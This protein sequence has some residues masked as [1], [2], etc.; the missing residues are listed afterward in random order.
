FKVSSVFYSKATNLRI[1]IV[2]YKI[3]F[4]KLIVLQ[5]KEPIDINLGKLLLTSDVIK[6]KEIVVKKRKRYRDTTNII[7]YDKKFERE[8][9]I[10]DLFSSKWGF[11]K[12]KVGKL[13]YNGKSVS[14]VLVNGYDF[15]GKNNLGI[16]KDLPALILNNIEIVETDIDS[17]TNITLLNPTVKVNLKLKEKYASGKFGNA[18]LGMGS[19][20]RYTVGT[21]LNMY[22]KN[23]Q[24]SVTLSSNNINMQEGAVREP[25]ISFSPN[26]NNTVNH[27]STIMY[28][29]LF[30]KKRI[31]FNAFVKGKIGDTKFE[32]ISERKDEV[33]GQFSNTSSSSNAKKKALDAMNFTFSYKIDS[34]N[35]LTVNQITEYNNTKQT[36]SSSYLIAADD[37][38]RSSSRINKN[39]S[40][41]S[42]MST[43]K[44]EYQKKFS[45]KK[46]RFLN[47]NI[48]FGNSR[49]NVNENNQVKERTSSIVNEYFINGNRRLAE[50]TINVNTEF[51][52]PID[53]MGYI[54]FLLAYKKERFSFDENL[55]RDNNIKDINSSTLYTYDYLKQGIKIYKNLNRLAIDAT[56]VGTANSR[57]FEVGSKKT[58]FN[59]DA[60]INVDYKLNKLRKLLGQYSKVTN[61]PNMT[62]LT[63]INSPFNIISQQLGNP[64]LRPEINDKLEFTYDL[65]KTDSSNISLEGNIR[66]YTSKFGFNISS[67]PGKPQTMF[68]DNVG[69]SMNSE[70]AFSISKNLINGNNFSYRLG[71]GYQEMPSYINRVRELRRG[72]TVNQLLA[73]NKIIMKDI[74]SFSPA[75]SV[76]LSKYYYQTNSYKQFNLIY[77]DKFSL[78]L[79]KFQLTISPMVSYTYI[80]KSNFSFATNLELKR[81]FLKNYASVWLKAYDVFNSYNYLNSLNS[82][83]YT[84]ITKFSNLSSYILLGANIKLNNMK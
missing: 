38:F 36:D 74:L 71:L 78:N 32:S 49:Y 41:N 42:L 21:D 15:F 18:N 80:I 67:S 76:S 70:L 3:Y 5:D 48:S 79:F 58:L 31:E 26:G 55:L 75:I 24:F 52:E 45:S 12:D 54:R 25:N 11:Y 23:Q 77:S 59:L 33:I 68:I 4:L 44:V 51:N 63:S 10:D 6:L 64:N 2:G 60:I 62:Q 17:L 84:Q 83:S 69:S 1:S 39:S 16:Y 30:Y 65:K 35:Y 72:F 40:F 82:A 50:K 27:G 53:D 46:G 14:D 29:N 8:I 13:Y 28:R 47:M 56:I 81:T 57:S 73:T 37:D 9:M 34:L 66:R 61:Y 19:L 20:K 7:L 43:Q 22:K